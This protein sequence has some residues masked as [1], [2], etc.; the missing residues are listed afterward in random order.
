MI[1]PLHTFQVLMKGDNNEAYGVQFDKHGQFFEAYA[2]KEVIISAGTVNSPKILMLSGIGTKAQLESHKV[3][4]Y[5][6]F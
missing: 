5:R 6:I 1:S 4:Q 3:N 2:R